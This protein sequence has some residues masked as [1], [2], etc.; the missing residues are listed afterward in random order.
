MTPGRTALRALIDELATRT[1]DELTYSLE[2]L[3]AMQPPLDAELMA[4][5]EHATRTRIREIR[6]D[7]S[8]DRIAK[9]R[10]ALGGPLTTTD[11][12]DQR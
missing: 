6:R 8:T 9:A 1:A 7:E 11:L 10:A 2:R 4:D 12:G 5:L 3:G